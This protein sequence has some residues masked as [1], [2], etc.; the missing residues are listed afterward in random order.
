VFSAAQRTASGGRTARQAGQERP[1]DPSPCARVF[2][3]FGGHSQLARAR[4]RG[5]VDR[6]DDLLYE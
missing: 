1:T 5:I 2:V 6:I 3:S 4:F